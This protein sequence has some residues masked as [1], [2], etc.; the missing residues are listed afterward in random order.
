MANIGL[1]GQPAQIQFM[2]RPT[3][4]PGV[5]AGL[6]YLSQID[7]LLVHQT[8]ELFELLT[9]WE[10]C[11]RYQVKNSLGQQVYYAAEESDAC[12]R[13][14]CGPMRGF[15]MHITDNLGQEVMRVSREFKCCAG[16]GWCAN[17]AHCAMTISV[18][19]PVGTV[20]GS[21]V[22]QCSFCA[23]SYGVHDA[24]GEKIMDILGPICRCQAVCCT[25]DIDFVITT[26]GG[27]EIGKISKQWGG[28]VREAFTKA[29]NF[30]VQFP[31]DLDVRIKAVLL[32]ATFLIDFMY[33]EQ[34]KDNDDL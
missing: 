26:T 14:C 3:L 34:R 11:N 17:F 2:V 12:A 30:G 13:Q 29:D 19:A 33:F 18:E 27:D 7:Q 22:Q 31:I 23:P 21:V 9:G 15:I 6:E 25:G 24:Q 20:V 5:P 32:G 10:T 4:I 28:F 8:V 1:L 16:C